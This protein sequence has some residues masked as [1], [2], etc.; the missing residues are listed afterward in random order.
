M[1]CRLVLR[2]IRRI[3]DATFVP[4]LSVTVGVGF[5][6]A[7]LGVLIYFIHHVAI[8]I[9]A[10]EVVARVSEEL[11]QSIERL[12]PEQRD[13]A[14]ANAECRDLPAGFAAGTVAIDA[15]G[16]G[17]LEFVDS[18]AL[19]KLAP[20][21]DLILRIERRAGQ[22]VIQGHALAFAYPQER[23]SGRLAEVT[24]AAFVLGSRSPAQD[25]R[26]RIQSSS[27][28]RRVERG[29]H[30]T[31]AGDNRAH[32][33]GCPS[34]RRHRSA[35]ATGNMIVSASRRLPIEGGDRRDIEEHYC[36]V[37]VTLVQRSRS[38]GALAEAA[39]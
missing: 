16:D 23:F 2:T 6:L 11:C 31:S 15:P 30:D 3:D 37:G 19:M 24:R 7:S 8:S 10:D 33:R 32:R 20:Q 25:A 4:E 34:A 28:A 13:Y 27:A 21:E 22:Y 18:E 36:Q 35:S 26:G 29:R 39:R 14:A 38:L 9:Q 5:A 1:Y 17:Y 12:L